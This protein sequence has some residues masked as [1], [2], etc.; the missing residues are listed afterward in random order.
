[1][2][3]D[4]NGAHDPSA[5]H[6]AGAVRDQR[7]DRTQGVRERALSNGEPE[8]ND[9]AGHYRGEHIEPKE[10]DRVDRTRGEG[11]RDKKKVAAL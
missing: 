9:V 8:Q 5:D 10:G 1:V 2:R 11:Q 6:N 4:R 3:L 7:D